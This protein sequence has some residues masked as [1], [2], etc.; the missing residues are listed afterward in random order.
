MAN[1]YSSAWA[2][3]KKT[4]LQL[5]L[6]N[7]LATPSVKK[8]SLFVAERPDFPWEMVYYKLLVYTN[9]AQSKT[10]HSIPTFWHDRS[11]S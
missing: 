6:H 9:S 5:V 10:L 7:Y 2:T 4:S 8:D 11:F 1:K 3:L